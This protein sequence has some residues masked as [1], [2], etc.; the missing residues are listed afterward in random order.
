MHVVPRLSP[1]KNGGR[2]EPG[3]I[4]VK[5]CRLPVPVSGGTNQIAEQNHVNIL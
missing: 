2:R 1:R 5:S 3:N 4:G